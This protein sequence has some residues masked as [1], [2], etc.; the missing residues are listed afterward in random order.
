MILESAVEVWPGDV[1]ADLTQD[2]F[3]PAQGLTEADLD[4]LRQGHPTLD[5]LTETHGLEWVRFHG[6]RL[7]L[8]GLA[9]LGG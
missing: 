9:R 3:F 4:T 8:L 6:L 1:L 7:C 5:S 2:R